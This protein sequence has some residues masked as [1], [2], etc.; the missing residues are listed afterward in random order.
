MEWWLEM[1]ILAVDEPR[2]YESLVGNTIPADRIIT[3]SDSIGSKTE[4]VSNDIFDNY[5]CFHIV[6]T[7]ELGLVERWIMLCFVLVDAP[8][9][10][11]E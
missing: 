1:R 10:Q 8:Y 11:I 4:G 5:S 6:G 9:S 3:R 2:L 7:E